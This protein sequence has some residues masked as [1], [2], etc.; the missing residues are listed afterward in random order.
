MTT[1]RSATAE[2]RLATRRQLQ[3]LIRRIERRPH[4]PA[5]RATPELPPLLSWRDTEAGRIG[6]RELRYGRND[7]V[8]TQSLAPLFE[9]DATSL[10]LLSR[11]NAEVGAPG[12]GARDLLF[13]DIETTG[14]GGAGAMVFMVAL[15]RIDG[16]DLVLRQYVSPTPADEAVLLDAVIGDLGLPADPVLVTYNGL[17]FDAPFV[18][19]RATLHR[20]RSG[21]QAARHLDLLHTVRRGYRGL[22][23]SHRLA[24]VEAEL[25]KVKR[26]ELEVGGA[27]VPAWY[28]RFIRGGSMRFLDP[29]LDH[30]A[31]DVLA[32]AALVAQLHEGAIGTPDLRQALA[33][34]RLAL[35]S[36]SYVAAERHLR[37]AIEGLTS[38]EARADAVRDL[39]IVCRTLGRRGD[40][41]PELHWLAES[42]AWHARWASQQL[43]IYYEHHA[44][45]LKQALTE[46]DAV[47]IGP[48]GDAA[49]TR[50]RQRLEGKLAC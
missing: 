49:W 36:R 22:L 40:A 34:R 26:P 42:S 13:F 3:D 9:V 23:T 6:Y 38:P 39:A 10:H 25:L 2:E 43:A 17:T 33:L 7:L 35:A 21:L 48:S 31:V 50:R 28:F 12:T 41:V 47:Q 8:G 27:E 14:L 5:P 45:D 11:G 1:A 46:V 20:R 15:A 19:E 24:T 18:D 44:R 37:A 30:N 29:L 32:L 16:T 4:P